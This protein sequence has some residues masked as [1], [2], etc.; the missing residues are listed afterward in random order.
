MTTQAMPSLV[1]TPVARAIGAWLDSER[2]NRALWIFLALFVGIWTGF[3]IISYAS[4]DLHSDI[5]EFYA[6]SRHPAAG[7]LKHPPLGAWMVAAWFAM[8]PAAGWSFHLLAMVNAAIGL[9]A[10]YCIARRYLDGDKRLIALLLLLLTP[11]YQF[12]G[13]RFGANQTL[14]STWPIAVYCYL[15]AFET[16]SLVWSVAAGAAAAL[17]MLG[18]YYSVYILTAIIIAALLHPAR[19]AYLRSPSPYV[20]A[21]TGLIVLGPHLRWLVASDFQPLVYARGV[22]GGASISTLID[23]AVQYIV[24]GVAYVALPLVVFALVTRVRWRELVDAVWPDDPERRMLIV[25]LAVPLLLPA[26]SAPLSGLT[27]TPLWTMSAWFLLPIVLLAPDGVILT[28]KAT[29]GVTAGVL[30]YSFALL[31][32]APAIAVARFASERNQ[33]DRIY[34]RQLGQALTEAWRRVIGRPLMFVTGDFANAMTFYSGDHPTAA[35]YGEVSLY[36]WLGQAR[37]LDEGWAAVCKAGD[38]GCIASAERLTPDAAEAR[39]VPFDATASWLGVHAPPGHFV[40]VLVP[41]NTRRLAV[42]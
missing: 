41:P 3:Q 9:G 19:W 4:L 8:F 5:V 14:L 2:Q 13:Q 22:H 42:Q 11:F 29:I 30:A 15:R 23:S 39:L 18:K 12:H 37:L 35:L 1:W 33:A 21:L 10:T 40:F 17:T 34:S 7:Y 27:L 16:R 6:W 24:G 25:L 38:A 36:P 20:S 31:A 32:V 28:R 26:V